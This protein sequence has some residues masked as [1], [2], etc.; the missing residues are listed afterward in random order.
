[1]NS[2]APTSTSAKL[3]TLESVRRQFQQDLI[4]VHNGRVFKANPATIYFA[5]C[6]EVIDKDGYPVPVFDAVETTIALKAKLL[7][8]YARAKKNYFERMAALNLEDMLKV[9]SS[10]DEPL[11]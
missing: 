3:I 11:E 1:M 9:E 4:V 8:A 10:A 7:D 5:S 6:G 2:N